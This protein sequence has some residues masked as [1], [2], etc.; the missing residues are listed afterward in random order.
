[1]II[2]GIKSGKNT[3]IDSDCLETIYEKGEQ[4]E[5]KQKKNRN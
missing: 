2:K 4:K 3:I 1:M 5:A